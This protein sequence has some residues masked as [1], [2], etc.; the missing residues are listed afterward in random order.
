MISQNSDRPTDPDQSS[1]ATERV[2]ASTQ[3]AKGHTSPDNTAFDSMKLPC[4]YEQVST[5]VQSSIAALGKRSF[6]DVLRSDL[7]ALIAHLSDPTT[8]SLV[9]THFANRQPIHSKA[10]ESFGVAIALSHYLN[11]G[12]EISAAIL[13]IVGQYRTETGLYGF[14]GDRFLEQARSNPEFLNVSLVRDSMYDFLGRSILASDRYASSWIE[15]FAGLNSEPLAEVIAL[16]CVQRATAGDM[17]GYSHLLEVLKR[18][19]GTSPDDALGQL[20]EAGLDPR[21]LAANAILMPTLADLGTIGRRSLGVAVAASFLVGVLFEPPL[22]GLVIGGA[23]LANAMALFQLRWQYNQ[24]KKGLAVASCPPA[25][26]ALATSAVNVLKW[27]SEVSP[28]AVA[29]LKEVSDARSVFADDVLAVID[30]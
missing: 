22:T 19:P 7:S 13:S 25:F 4:T 23:I 21:K 17:S 29:R 26:V 1:R 3:S 8:R 2:Q 20:L 6:E 9:A 28:A 11:S 12:P 5:E 14:V 18:M 10:G 27:R 15:L 24:M 30:Q 16:S